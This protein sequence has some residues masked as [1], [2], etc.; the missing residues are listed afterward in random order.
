MLMLIEKHHWKAKG[1]NTL[2]FFRKYLIKKE[3]LVE[4]NVDIN[5]IDNLVFRL[6]KMV[7]KVFAKIR[8]WCEDAANWNEG[9]WNNY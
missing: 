8:T 1:L 7:K 6:G 9:K 4:N 5:T 3:L 2:Q